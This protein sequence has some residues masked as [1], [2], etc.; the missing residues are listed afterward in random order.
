M[1]ALVVE[2][3]AR[4]SGVGRKLMEFAELWALDRG[5]SS[6]ALSSHISRFDA[7]AFYQRLG[8]QIGATSHLMRKL[9]T[10]DR[11]LAS[12]TL[13]GKAAP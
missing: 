9:L 3:T 5:S 10:V 13:S 8:Y 6:I 11:R 12:A 2:E 1:Q 4:G 7:H